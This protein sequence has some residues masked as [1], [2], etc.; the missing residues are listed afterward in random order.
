MATAYLSLGSN[1]GDR[2][3]LIQEAVA[4]L[5]VEAGPV[6]ALSSLYET[7]PWGFSSPHRF[8]NVALALETTLSPE[9]L[10]AVTQRIE[11][12]L[13]RTHKSVDGRYADRTID[14]DLLFVGDAV[15]DTP[16]LTLPHPRLHL[17]RFVLEPLCEIA[18]ALLHP[19]LRKSVSQL[20][21]EL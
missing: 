12:D 17:R 6:T 5:T 3:R 9:I 21:A 2:L 10:L 8:L 19:L 18:P 11:R 7:E 20:L 14:I 16:A 15:L 1:L 4:A 13:G